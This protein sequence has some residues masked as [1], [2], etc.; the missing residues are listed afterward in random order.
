MP[1][2]SYQ[3]D[4]TLVPRSHPGALLESADQAIAQTLSMIQTGKVRSHHGNPVNV[5]AETVCLHGDGAH[6]LNFA[7][8]LCDA[9]AQHDIMVTSG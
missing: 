1:I 6:A 7:V 5:T 9:F 8:Q 4:G 2:C 3:D